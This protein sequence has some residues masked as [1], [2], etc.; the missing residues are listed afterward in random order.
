MCR[1][2]AH[3]AHAGG[4]RGLDADRGILEDDRARGSTPALAAATRKT[5]GSG[6]PLDILQRG[7]RG[8]A[9][10]EAADL[11]RQ[12]EV[13]RTPLDPIASRTLARE[14]VEQSRTPS[15]SAIWPRATSR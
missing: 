15:I 9:A 4:L 8:E 5:C 14:P 7:D 2:D 13:G 3:G 6:L 12:V 11:D 10:L 1:G